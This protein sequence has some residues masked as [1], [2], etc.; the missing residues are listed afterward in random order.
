[1]D[2][3]IKLE[4]VEQSGYG[5]LAQ[6]LDLGYIDIFCSPTW[7]STPRK[8]E[9][10]FSDSLMESKQYAYLRSDS[11]YATQDLESL[12]QN[13]KIRIAVRE[14]DNHYYL[15]QQYFPHARLIR[16][17]QLSRIEEVIRFVL[18]NRADMTFWDEALVE[19][20]CTENNIAA[21]ILTQ[22]SF[23]DE[24]IITYDNC[25]ALPRGEFELKKM[26]DEGIAKYVEHKLPMMQL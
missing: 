18:D 2:N 12:K 21:N 13:K 9:M 8:L 24:P 3:G 1:M 7:P 22:K 17:P 20:Y 19:K 16:V 14:N 6:R 4:F 26:I 23:S 11:P 15:A 10:F 25:Y 5:T